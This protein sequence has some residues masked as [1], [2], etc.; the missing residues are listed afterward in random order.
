M[1][2]QPDPPAKGEE[3]RLAEQTKQLNGEVMRKQAERE[4]LLGPHFKKPTRV[5]S[6]SISGWLGVCEEELGVCEEENIR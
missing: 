5:S 2:R 3:A 6:L 4:N 1:P